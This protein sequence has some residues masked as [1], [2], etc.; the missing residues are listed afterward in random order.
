MQPDAAHGVSLA[1]DATVGVAYQDTATYSPGTFST[2]W[3]WISQD[4]PVTPDSLIQGL[5]G[6]LGP[7]SLLADWVK[8]IL[9]TGK[10]VDQISSYLSAEPEAQELFTVEAQ[11]A[12]GLVKQTGLQ[13]VTLTVPQPLLNDYAWFMLSDTKASGYMGAALASAKKGHL[14]AT[15]VFAALSVIEFDIARNE[16]DQAIDPTDPNY[17]QLASPVPISLPALESLPDSPY[18]DIVQ[19]AISVQADEVAQ[20]TSLNRA[21]GAAQVGDSYWQA[22]QLGAAAE[23]AAQ[24]S[25]LEDEISAEFAVV[26]S[27]VAADLAA[28]SGQVVSDLQSNGL[29]QPVTDVLSQAGW[30]ADEINAYRQ[31]LIQTGGSGYAD[32]QYLALGNEASSL[33]ETTASSDNVQQQIAVQVGPLGQ[34]V[35]DI[36]PS[37]QQALDTQQSQITSGLA[38]GVPSATLQSQ[39]EAYLGNVLQLEQQ[40]NNLAG[41][42]DDFRFGNNAIDSFQQLI[43]FGA[44]ATTTALS[45]PQTSVA[46]GTP[47]T[48]TTIVSAQS[49]SA[50]PSGSV[51]FFDTTANR[52]LGTGTFE[53]STGTTS[54]WTLTTGLKTFN[55]TA[56][57]IITAAYTPGTGSGFAGSSGTTTE[58]V[59]A[60]PITVTA[61]PDIKIYDGTSSASSVPTITSGSLVAGDTPAFSETFDTPSAGTGKTLTPAGSVNDGNSGGNYQ[62]TLVANTAGVITQTVDH[63]VAAADPATVTAGAPF[64][65]TV[66][67]LD[68]TGQTVAG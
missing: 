32:A 36:D 67:A 64:L 34:T 11:D 48:F 8:G 24:A 46:Y 60:M 38:A 42:Q 28:Y 61:A 9:D 44:S 2:G 7:E 59:T 13:D 1:T 39:I 57:D 43:G 54:T 53:S 52:D 5:Q 37:A 26:Q 68:A 55:V 62:V 31:T 20:A 25:V 27:D 30:T 22:Q 18:K 49:G 15:T 33:L 47:V 58:T 63:F 35:S 66:T 19:A 12:S 17:T 10:A 41:L 50:A 40:T 4:N 6:A 45:G 14:G 16:Y 65:Y 23:F 29:P 21:E 51:D 56:G 3:H